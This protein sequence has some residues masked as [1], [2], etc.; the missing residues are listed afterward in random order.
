MAADAGTV[1]AAATAAE[2]GVGIGG[3]E[4]V[5]SLPYARTS[6]L[7]SVRRGRAGRRR[8]FERSPRLLGGTLLGGLLLALRV[9]DL[10]APSTSSVAASP[11]K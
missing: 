6:R 11:I 10:R 4:G 1:A 5:G 9:V 3:C 2:A 8:G 7:G